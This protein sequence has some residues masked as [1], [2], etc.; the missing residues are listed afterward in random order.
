MRSTLAR[1]PVVRPASLDEQSWNAD[2]ATFCR[3]VRPGDAR[4]I[5]GDAGATRTERV[6]RVLVMGA[7]GGSGRA[8]VDALVE[9]GHEVTAFARR[10]TTSFAGR[11]GVRP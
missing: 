8:A 3:T 1:P 7:T 9:R 5:A 2:S 10:A 6:M 11:A 4:R